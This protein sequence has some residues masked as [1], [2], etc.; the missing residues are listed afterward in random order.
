MT[1]IDVTDV[2]NVHTLIL[3]KTFLTYTEITFSVVDV[4]Q[5]TDG[6]RYKASGESTRVEWIMEST[7][8]RISR[9]QHRALKNRKQP[10]RARRRE[11]VTDVVFSSSGFR[12]GKSR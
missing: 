7:S 9:R 6:F 2:P 3:S 12:L 8:D 5:H 11:R 1:S 4:L 10:A